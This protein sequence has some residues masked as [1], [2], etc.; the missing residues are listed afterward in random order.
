MKTRACFLVSLVLALT[1][2]EVNAHAEASDIQAMGGDPSGCQVE[3]SS[4][5]GAYYR[6]VRSA[7]K[8][9]G[10]VGTIKVPAFV[11]NASRVLKVTSGNLQNRPDWDGTLDRPSLYVGAHSSSY[12]IDTGIGW[13]PVK[14]GDAPRVLARREHSQSQSRYDRTQWF[15]LYEKIVKTQN[16]A[17]PWAEEFEPYLKSPSGDIVARGRENIRSYV[18]ENKL[19][20]VFAFKPFV[21]TSNT[22]HRGA[23]DKVSVE[24][25][26]DEFEQRERTASVY[27]LGDSEVVDGRVVPRFHQW[28]ND[29]PFYYVPGDEIEIQLTH[30]GREFVLKLHSKQKKE[31]VW[32]KFHQEGFESAFDVYSFKRVTSIDQYR[33]SSVGTRV[34]NEGAGVGAIAT[35]AKLVGGGWADFYVLS[36]EGSQGSSS[37]RRTPLANS[38]CF[39]TRA[40]DLASRYLEVFRVQA[41]D[42]TN[43]REFVDILPN[44]GTLVQN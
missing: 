29:T 9:S 17:Q 18:D 12:Q 34:A 23:L 41:F 13:A 44:N 16:S 5:R 36:S 25:V 2:S 32:F 24:T 38:N 37:G 21:R 4:W 28:F 43:G 30:L 40:D 31:L 14:D 20:F 15:R 33:L 19:D 39:N 22:V 42:V 3:Y 10:L 27:E 26:W 11:E 6:K 7:E 35:S 8:Y 1:V